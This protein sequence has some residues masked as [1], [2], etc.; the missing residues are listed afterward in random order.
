MHESNVCPKCRHNHIL[1]IAQVADSDGDFSVK[2]LKAAIVHRGTSFFGAEKLGTAG[3]ISAYVCKRCGYTELY[4]QGVDQIPID[5]T[6]VRELVGP[7]PDDPS[8]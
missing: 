2:Q 4:T 1:A 7:E 8:R 5:G 3:E 6:R